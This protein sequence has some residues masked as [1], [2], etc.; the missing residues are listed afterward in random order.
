MQRDLERAHQ[1][2]QLDDPASIEKA[3]G[4]LQRTVFSFSMKICGHPADAEDT[5]QDVLLKAL[6]Y[7]SKFEDPKALTVWLYK[8]A[9]NQCMMNR[10]RSKFSPKHDLSLSQL[11]P[12]GREMQELLESHEPNP[13]SRA[14]WGAQLHRAVV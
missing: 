10:R 8:V 13:E 4:L 2:I 6:P 7:F 3:L 14:M 11:M 5:M 1:V 12:D 9:R